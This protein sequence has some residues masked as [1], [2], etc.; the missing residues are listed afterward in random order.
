LKLI[1]WLLFAPIVLI[2]LG[3]LGTELNKAYWDSKVK[4]LCEK[5]GGVT[6]FEKME[7][8]ISDYP[9]IK[10]S[11]NNQLI[12]PSE[13]NA[14]P[15]DPFFYRYRMDYLHRG[16]V[17]VVRHEQSIIRGQ[18]RKVL[19]THISFGRGGGDFPTGFHPSHY[20]CK[21]RDENTRIYGSTVIVKGE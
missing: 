1:K 4:A 14:K 10:L 3:V 13:R 8:S 17:D 7:I 5:E 20:S 15:E 6:V 12:M 2:G 16:F 21:D 11:S 9:D 19:S 18:D